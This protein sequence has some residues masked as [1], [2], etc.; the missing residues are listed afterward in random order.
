MACKSAVKGGDP[1]N[2]DEV[3][4]LIRQ[5]LSTGAPP[6]CPHG[7]PVMK[8]IRKVTDKQ[9]DVHLMVDGPERYL[10]DFKDCGA[11]IITVHIETL[12]KPVETLKAIREL[13]VK[14]GIAIS[15]ETPIETIYPYLGLVDLVLVMTVRP[16]IG[17]Q[18]YMHDCT[19][20]IAAV[21]ME[22]TKLQLR[23]KVDVSVDGGI[24]VDTVDEAL[25]AG[26][27]VIVAGTAVY[28]DGDIAENVKA[29]MSHF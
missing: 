2:R 18:S 14:A 5:M 21:T 23:H 26:A 19:A 3:E 12:E 13:G 25:H 4:S 29:I 17:G 7:R 24:D 16:G 10:K 1:L 6:T 28:K 20:K 27:N 11:D 9:F 22:L 15:P 8:S